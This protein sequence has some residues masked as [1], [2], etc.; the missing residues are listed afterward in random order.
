MPFALLALTVLSP[1]AQLDLI[2]DVAKDW[3]ANVDTA[4]AT[5]TLVTT[6][7]AQLAAQ[8]VG[9][10]GNESYPKLHRAFSPDEDFSR[11]TRLRARVRVT[12]DDTSV[13]DMRAAFV[14]YDRKTLRTDLPAPYPMTQ[15]CIGHT[16]PIGKWVDL[17][18][19]LLNINRSAIAQL[20]IYLY[21]DV[22]Q[23]HKYRWEIAR[24]ELEGVGE[25]ALVFDT[26]IYGKS[27]L[28]KPPPAPPP[29]A[30][31]LATDDGLEL[32]VAAS[33]Q[34]S[35]G[36]RKL[37]RAGSP[38]AGFM[39]RDVA[40]GDLP[41]PVGGKFE[42]SGGGF[43]QNA[44]LDKLGLRVDA[45]Y[46]SRGRYLEVAGNVTN[47]R[48][49]DRAV[50][51]YFALPVQA[52]PWQ[53]WDS[54]AASRTDADASGEMSCLEIGNAWGLNGAH[55][56]Y[57]LSALS[58]PGRGGLSLAV[59]MDEPVCHRIGYNKGLG[60]L[61]IAFDFGLLGR[62]KTPESLDVTSRDRP[63]AH[64]PFRLLLYSHDPAWGFRSALQRYYDFFPDFFTRRLKREGGWFVWGDMSKTEGALDAGF[65]FH[66]GPSGNDAVRWDNQNGSLALLYIEPEFYQQ[67]HG[68]F[69]HSPTLQECLDRLDKLAAGDQAETARTAKLSYAGGYAPGN[70]TAAHGGVPGLLQTVA[71]AAKASVSHDSGGAPYA[72]IGKMP[73]MGETQWGCIFPCDLD[74]QIPDGKG[75]FCRNAY[76]DPGLA[77]AEAHGAHYDGIG[78]DSFGGY[79]QALRADYRREHFA[80][81]DYP[82]CF[83]NPER[84][85]IRVTAFASVEFVRDL[86]H[87]MHA[88]GKVLMANCS[89]GTTPAWLT[90]AAPYLDIFGAEAPQM[91]DPDYIRAIAYR[92]A[93]T[94]LPYNPVPD[95]QIPWHLLHD[96]YPGAGNKLDLMKQY[97][98]LLRDLSAAGWEPLTYARADEPS[99]RLERYGSGKRI[100][101]VAHNP[102]DKPVTTRIKLDAAALGLKSFTAAALQPSAPLSLSN[103]FFS[104]SLPAQSTL[105]ILLERT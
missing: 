65:A 60:V 10:G 81:T 32:T 21:E 37:T 31:R 33:P 41:V 97:A 61:Y 103:D 100:Y 19:W 95:W 26:E 29:A 74:M 42:R 86:A 87:D 63:L 15:Q 64:A 69:D 9:A 22:P 18:D 92:K 73:W 39:V 53:W 99:V 66:W 13:R 104:L 7:D 24:L 34:V 30:P 48:D 38:F 78:L 28:P 50:T 68:D 98:A 59:R 56:K 55:S 58:L 89:W 6:H 72:M 25:T 2:G 101:L 79:G 93:C 44:R 17:S 36:G 75:W 70:W 40:A 90:F 105:A 71:R 102:G 96:I 14:F 11:F 82:L 1:C 16:I 88:R 80:Y 5:I 4:P 76:L 3:S 77:D 85:P 51:L 94:D 43:V 27:G 20:D 83:S 52:G 45:S 49:D 57:P 23:P 84:V 46:R 62:L 67:T 35:L 12:T 8:I 47:L 91:A 54:I